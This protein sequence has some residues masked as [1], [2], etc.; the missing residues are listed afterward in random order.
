M[1]ERYFVKTKISKLKSRDFFVRSIASKET[2]YRYLGKKKVYNK[3]RDFSG[4]AWNAINIADLKEVLITSDIDVVK[5]PNLQEG[6]RYME[7][8]KVYVYGRYH[9][10]VPKKEQFKKSDKLIKI[11]QRV[12]NESTYNGRKRS[13]KIMQELYDRW[14]KEVEKILGNRYHRG[15]IQYD[16][17][18]TP[19][20][21]DLW[22]ILI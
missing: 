22:D 10:V 8:G 20:T 7:N 14:D 13:S 17:Y 9:A 4:W 5:K 16:Q 1:D 2:I 12:W 15:M 19:Y 6:D 21:Y 18:D 3:N 11:E